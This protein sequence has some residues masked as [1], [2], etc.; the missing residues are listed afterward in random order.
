M[1]L[2]CRLQRCH[3]SPTLAKPSPRNLERLVECVALDAPDV[4]RE[5]KTDLKTDTRVALLVVEG[6][7]ED[8]ITLTGWL[9]AADG[10]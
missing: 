7:G 3:L 1:E 8:Q 6:V 5:A 10:S 2:D 4:C 9:I